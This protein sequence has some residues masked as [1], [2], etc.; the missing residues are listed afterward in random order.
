MDRIDKQLQHFS[1]R[2]NTTCQPDALLANPPNSAS[3]YAHWSC[4]AV[5]PCSCQRAQLVLWLDAIGGV[6]RTGQFRERAKAVS[7]GEEG[8]RRFQQLW[9]CQ[10]GRWSGGKGLGKRPRAGSQSARFGT[11]QKRREL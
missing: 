11:F 8:A 4:P 10:P 2:G 7:A 1:D 5:L 6:S 9:R 3:A